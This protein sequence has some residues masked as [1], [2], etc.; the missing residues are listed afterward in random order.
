M[1]YLTDKYRKNSDFRLAVQ[2]L[3]IL[4]LSRLFMLVMM[5]VYNAV[6]GTDRSISFLMNQWDAKRYQFMIDNGY[7]FPLDT[8]PQANWAF[9]PM[10]VLVCQAVKLLTFWKGDTYWIGMFV[11]NVCIYIAAF[12][13]VK[14]LRNRREGENISL[15][16]GILMFAAPYTFY[17]SS[18][19]TEAMFIMFISLF[20]YFCQE[21]KYLL[22]GLMSAFAS[23]T[24]IVGCTLVF[25]LIVE[26][27]ENYRRENFTEKNGSR[28]SERVKAFIVD[29]LKKPKQILA[30]LICPF[31]TFAYM[32]FLKFFCGDV[33][34]FMHVQIAWREDKYFPVIGVLWKA[35]TGQI[36]P[37]YTYMGW[38]CIA[39]FAV[40][41]YMLYRKYYSMA[42]FGIISLL[43]PLT[44]H[45]MSTCR[46]IIGTY[47][48]FVGVYDLM[49]YA[50]LRRAAVP[51]A[52]GGL[53]ARRQ[54]LDSPPA[55]G[56][57]DLCEAIEPADSA[58]NEN[59]VLGWSR[60]RKVVNSLILAAFF[61]VEGIL[62]F[63][64]YNS[65]CWLM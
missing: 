17:C 45:V 27:Y 64:W 55:D 52:G 49:N 32:T 24:R 23:A 42:V 41:A 59:A 65:D 36:E 22:A 16:L 40:Y 28:F 9:F 18:A 48:I 12:Y 2:L 13:G 53:T 38:F 4:V 7:T 31:G 5:I 35:C 6:M 57:K 19:Y 29:F 33:W 3:F 61:I 50:G 15:L 21:K 46:F 56:C 30:V 62:L 34:A 63:L 20:F 43:V 10:Y 37:R 54:Q 39:A 60:R 47:V 51:S 14:W 58:A 1:N 11:S 8:D 26:L 25:A 44:S